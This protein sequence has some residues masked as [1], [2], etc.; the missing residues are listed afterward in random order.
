MARWH[1]F[2]EHF[3]FPLKV[4]FLATVLLGIG[5]S[6]LNPNIAFVYEADNNILIRIA[7]L[8]RY[9]GGFLIELFP[10]LV[11]VKVLAKKFEAT[12][13]VLV[14]VAGYFIINIT[15][16]FFVNS[17]LPVYF[18]K[19][20]LGISINFDAIKTF[21]EGIVS[22]FNVG[23][24]SLIVTYIITLYCYKK[25]RHYSMHGMLS[26]VDHDTWSMILTFILC[27]FAGYLFAICWPIV[28]SIM[29]QVFKI[30]GSDI[31]NPIYLFIYGIG[32]RITAVLN[33]VEIPRSVFWFG[34][35]GGSWM[36]ASGAKYLGDVGVWT[37]Q[38]NI[39]DGL[40]SAGRLITPYYIINMFIIPGFLL[41]YYSLVTSL[42]DKKRYKAFFILAIFISVIC[43][44]ALPMEILMLILCPLLYIFYLF[45]VGILF[46]L[47]QILNVSVG[48]N[49]S[50]AL[51]LA[52]PG[53][54]LELLQYVRNPEMIR[55][56]TFI[57]VIGLFFGM[58]FFFATRIYFRK[59]AIGV[60]EVKNADKMSKDLAKALG[61]INNIINIEFTPDKLTVELEDRSLVDFIWLKAIGAYLVIEAKNGYLLRMGNLSTVL[62]LHIRQQIE[63]NK[64]RSIEDIKINDIRQ[65]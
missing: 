11:F 65:F 27:A 33:M 9:I 4:L 57:L 2:M 8:L 49:F 30:I 5:S 24:F 58:I 54:S 40:S 28:I 12:V 37:I 61:G 53:S 21:G 59:Y 46:G 10:F 55:N 15:M 43:G 18:Y 25:S 1:S 44:N 16:I 52:Q 50:D 20:I 31:T 14:G 47:L 45:L 32:E 17:E 22:P 39:S 60:L 7:E 13:P 51:M 62:G 36:D 42:K 63:N 41:A 64:V 29:M 38:Q 26:F 56:L 34:D 6:I 48:Y 35:L 3:Q 23:I 19:S